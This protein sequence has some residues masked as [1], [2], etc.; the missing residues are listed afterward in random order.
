MSSMLA[1]STPD[2][3]PQAKSGEQNNRNRREN[4]PFFTDLMRT[5]AIDESIN[6]RNYKKTD[7]SAEKHGTDKS[8][9]QRFL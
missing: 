1:C 9:D 2:L 4:L 6:M 5:F 7:E 3:C 8:D